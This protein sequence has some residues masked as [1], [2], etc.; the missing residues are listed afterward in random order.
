MFILFKSMYNF[1]SIFSDFAFTTDYET[2]K[3]EYPKKV[4]EAKAPKKQIR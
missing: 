2:Y 1:E 3:Y 4:Q